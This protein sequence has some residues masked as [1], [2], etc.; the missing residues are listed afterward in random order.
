[1]EI[2]AEALDLAINDK[3][4]VEKITLEVKNSLV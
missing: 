4:I 2:Q 3:K 1:M